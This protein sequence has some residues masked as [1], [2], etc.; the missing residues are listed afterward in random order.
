MKTKFALFVGG[1]SIFCFW[2]FVKAAAVI[3]ETQSPFLIF[4]G[5]V[6]IYGLFL[7]AI[8][9]EDLLNENQD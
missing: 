6:G 2:V 9:I 7:S 4:N 1:Y 3:A 5:V 8:W